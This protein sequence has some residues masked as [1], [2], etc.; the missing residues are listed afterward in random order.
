MHADILNEDIKLFNRHYQNSIDVYF[1]IKIKRTY[2]SW[3]I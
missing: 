1:N 2:F 3:S